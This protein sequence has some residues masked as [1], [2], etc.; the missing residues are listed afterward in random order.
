MI[1]TQLNNK[2][3]K[4]TQLKAGDLIYYEHIGVYGRPVAYVLCV[5]EKTETAKL[6]QHIGLSSNNRTMNDSLFVDVIY[7]NTNKKDFLELRKSENFPSAFSFLV[8]A[9]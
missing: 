4:D 6:L 5:G 7:L 1:I 8:R 9:E 2:L 3:V